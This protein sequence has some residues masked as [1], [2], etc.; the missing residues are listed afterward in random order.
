MINQAEDFTDTRKAARAA[1]AHNAH[2]IAGHALRLLRAAPEGLTA[3]EIAE[4]IGASII[5]VRPRISDL[6]RA[7]LIRDSGARRHARAG[8]GTDQVVFVTTEEGGNQ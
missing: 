3:D 7:G 5:S 8:A 4:R 1:S 2:A 6:K